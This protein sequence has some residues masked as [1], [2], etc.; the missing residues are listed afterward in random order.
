[1]QLT[2]TEQRMLDGA[3]GEAVRRVLAYQLEIGRFAHPKA[4][5]ENGQ[6]KIRRVV[7]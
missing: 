4:E 1:V 3:E 2:A 5:E 7:S 6:R